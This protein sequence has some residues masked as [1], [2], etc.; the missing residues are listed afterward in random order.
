MA[1]FKLISNYISFT[2]PYLKDPDLTGPHSR[3]RY[4]YNRIKWPITLQGAEQSAGDN[5]VWF[6]LNL[7]K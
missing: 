4:E 1:Q 5:E 2:D 6:K 7:L 3:G